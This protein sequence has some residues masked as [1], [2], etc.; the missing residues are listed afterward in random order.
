MKTLYEQALT[1][2]QYTHIRVDPND[3]AAMDELEEVAKKFVDTAV[4]LK[5]GS[6]LY[7]DKYWAKELLGDIS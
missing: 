1:A 5:G 3:Q 7:F 4:L 6:A 2:K